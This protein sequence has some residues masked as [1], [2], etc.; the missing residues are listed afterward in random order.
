MLMPTPQ[1]ATE[2]EEVTLPLVE[3]AAFP[4]EEEE[5]TVPLVEEAATLLSAAGAP[6]ASASPELE[7]LA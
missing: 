7:T 6:L 5:A 3:E 2:E 4:L 1:A